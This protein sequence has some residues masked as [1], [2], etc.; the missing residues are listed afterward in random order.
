MNPST[1]WF[2][3]AILNYELRYMKDQHPI[4]ILDAENHL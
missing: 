3:I 1:I 4:I 2:V